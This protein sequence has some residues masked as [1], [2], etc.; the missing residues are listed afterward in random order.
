M[1]DHD[2]PRSNGTTVGHEP[3]VLPQGMTFHAGELGA[4]YVAGATAGR[5]HQP[6]DRQIAQACDAYMKLAHLKR[7]AP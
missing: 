1:R 3:D 5:D 2:D 7:V 6:T 4:A